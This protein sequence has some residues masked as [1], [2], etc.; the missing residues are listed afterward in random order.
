M[1]MRILIMGGHHEDSLVEKVLRIFGTIWVTFI[2]PLMIFSLLVLS[3]LERMSWLW[4]FGTLA[5][6]PII[7]LCILVMYRYLRKN[8]LA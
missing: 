3:F 4:F 1:L 6:W 8:R 2:A 7:Y 5:L